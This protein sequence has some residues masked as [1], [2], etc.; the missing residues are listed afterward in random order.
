M[1]KG[2]VSLLVAAVLLAVCLAPVCAEGTV[3][4]EGTVLEIQKYGNVVLSLTCTELF[5]AG[6]AYG[7]VVTVTVGENVYEMPLGSNYADVDQGS[8]ICRAVFPLLAG[9]TNIP[10]RL[11]PW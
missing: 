1:K 9:T 7:D 8:M 6:F 10:A 3:T 4:A 2:F 11:A 5:G